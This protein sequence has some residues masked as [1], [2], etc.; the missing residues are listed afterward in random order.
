MET[1]F[2]WMIGRLSA[3]GRVWTALAPALLLASYFFVGLLFYFVRCVRKGPYRDSEIESRG[4]SVLAGMFLRQ[5]FA[6]VMQPVWRLI[7]RTGIP[8]TAVT[9]LSVL[10]ATA[11]GVALSV[12]RFALGG[13][14]YI[15]AGICDF[16]DGRLA[17]ASNTASRSGA[18]LD[19]VLDRYSDAAILVGLA[20]YYRDSWVL[21]ATQ[22]ALVGSSLVPYIRARG[23]AAGVSIK[24]VGFMQRAERI[25]YLG[26]AVAMSPIVEVAIAPEDGRPLHRLAVVGVVLLAFSTQVTALQRFV[27]L[28]G[29]LDERWGVGWFRNAQGPFTR[30]VLAAVVATLVDFLIYVGLV[31]GGWM[32]APVAVAFG[33][34][35]GALV[36]FTTNRL[37]T[38]RSRDAR[39]PQLGRYGFVSLTSALLNAGGVAVLL[40]LPSIN[41]V[42]AWA[43]VHGAVF[44][45]WNFPLHRGYVFKPR[46]SE[47]A[48][49]AADGRLG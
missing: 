19:S 48:A 47:P 16:L 30:N 45:A 41:Y 46:R 33:N 42:L 26:V 5:Y 15:F 3:E 14:L 10:L 24:E 28:L 37:W 49:A 2:D 39:L 31:A 1:A 32:S 43:F 27:H 4:S 12:G 34:L 35:S 38:F 44:I 13:W 18:A 6:W 25:L 20:W 17:R 21:L 36:N 40:L 11:S 9:T 23:E 8:A 7:L 22:V 29:A